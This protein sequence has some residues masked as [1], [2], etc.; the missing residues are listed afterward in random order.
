MPREVKI[1]EDDWSTIYTMPDPKTDKNILQFL[2]EERIFSIEIHEQLGV[3]LR[4]ECDEHFYV[5]LSKTDLQQL[6]K[7]LQ[8]IEE[9]CY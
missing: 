1:M 5:A 3:V 6:I 7:E 2:K 9:K 4:E 8:I